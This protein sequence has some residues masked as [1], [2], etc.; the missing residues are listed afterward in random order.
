MEDILQITIILFFS[1]LATL[2]S[3]KLKIPE[4]V[5]QMLI[6]IIL[7]PSV[8]G[9]INGGHTIEVM[10]E[11]GVILLMFL[12]G[13]ESDL[14]VLKKNLK[15]SILVALSGVIIPITIFGIV[16]FYSGRSI[17]TSLF[18]GIVF[19]AT[20]VSITVKVLQE[21]G[22]LSTKAGNIIL[23]AAVVDDILAILILSVFK[24]FKNS[25]GNLIVQFSMEIL[26]FV[27][28]FFVHKFIPKV[29]KFINKLPIY[30]K[31]TTSALIICLG[32]SLLA[33]KVGMSAVIGSFFA[34]IAISQT[35]VSEIIEEYV[36]AIGYVIFIPIFFVSIAIS[37]SFDVL[38]EHPFIVILFTLL[39]ILTKFLPAYY[40]GKVCNLK[41]S[42]S[43]L[44]GTGMVSRGEMSLI[45]AQIGLSGAIIN[46]NIYSELVIVIILTTLLAPFLIKMVIKKDSARNI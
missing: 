7:A 25:E 4:V 43:L 35:E 3:K 36:S 37:I 20:S 40:S 21:Y 10:S 26:F 29:W 28:L 14:E 18:Y 31:N 2:L 27:F 32:L 41:K 45:V 33:D 16:A 38:F 13:L 19:A 1:M 17:S 12:A 6:G 24:S 5:G 46:K 44:I 34:G 11:I 22:Y 39:A 23:G 15:P 30:A 9:L 8:L 42:E